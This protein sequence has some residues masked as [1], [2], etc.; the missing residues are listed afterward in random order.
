MPPPPWNYGL[1]LSEPIPPPHPPAPPTAP[2]TPESAPIKLTAKARR[3]PNWKP[4]QT[5]MVGKLQD[6]P[7]KSDEPPE[8][9]T[10]IPMGAA[11]LRISSFPVIGHGDDAKEWKA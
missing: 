6:S 1:A 10:L 4:D 11:R 8:T 9:I 5:G 3:I 2:F 7:I